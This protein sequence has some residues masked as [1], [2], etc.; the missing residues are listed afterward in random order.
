MAQAISSNTGSSLDALAAEKK[1]LDDSL[2][3][4][5]ARFVEF[6]EIYNVR[7]KTAAPDEAARLRAERSQLEETLGV[8]V[9]VERI[10]AVSRQMAELRG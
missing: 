8:E 10:D 5:L 9:L 7:I 1:R 3:E 6:E 2:S 4:A